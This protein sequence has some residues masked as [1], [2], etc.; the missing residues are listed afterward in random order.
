[1][2]KSG[3]PDF[4]K[5]QKKRRERAQKTYRRETNKMMQRLEKAGLGQT[6]LIRD[7]TGVKMSEVL[8][9][10]IEPYYHGVDTE[11]A[12]RK[13]VTTALVAWNT[14]LMPTEAQDEQLEAVA[15]AL[16][17]ETVEDFYVIVGEMIERKNRY[18]AEYT[19]YILDYEL[20][21]EGDDYHISV[22]STADPDSEEAE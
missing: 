10:F 15:Q 11:E 17:D 13:L 20:T 6:K 19:R 8:L 9:D 18:F 3:T 12:M 5:K 16:P 22:I 7:P 21:G 4:R 14:A 2:A 1:M